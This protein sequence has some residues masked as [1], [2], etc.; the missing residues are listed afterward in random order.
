M[1]KHI[2]DDDVRTI[3]TSKQ[4][5]SYIEAVFAHPL[6]LDVAE[7]LRH[8]SNARRKEEA[9]LL[10]DYVFENVRSPA[11]R[12]PMMMGYYLRVM[13]LQSGVDIGAYIQAILKEDTDITQRDLNTWQIRKTKVELG[14]MRPR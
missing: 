5:E 2:E 6:N 14:A 8:E 1:S 12:H 13:L 7:T 11:I 10:L 3:A 4:K 9:Q